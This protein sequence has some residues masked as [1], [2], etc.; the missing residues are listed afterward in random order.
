M[1][2]GKLQQKFLEL[3]NLGD[4]DRDNP[5]NLSR[6]PTQE[7]TAVYT[8]NVISEGPVL[9]RILHILVDLGIKLDLYDD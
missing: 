6:V 7:I 4:I 3:L 1:K 8:S 5:L 2:V 9:N